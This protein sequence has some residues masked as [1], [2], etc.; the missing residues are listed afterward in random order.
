MKIN[1][2]EIKLLEISGLNPEALFADGFENALIGYV[3]QGGRVLAA[4]SRRA[5]INILIERDDMTAEEAEEFFQ[6]NVAG[7]YVGE[8]TPVFVTKL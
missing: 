4:Y 6:H 2:S 3:E 5:C 7:A 1:H 8:N